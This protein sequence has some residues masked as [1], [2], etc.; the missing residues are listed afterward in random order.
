MKKWMY[1][2]LVVAL[3]VTPLSVCAQPLHENNLK[4]SISSALEKVQ[5]LQPQDSIDEIRPEGMTPE[6]CE[7]I[8]D[9]RFP[10]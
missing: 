8:Q 6:L 4:G 3:A 9:Y 1:A 7:L 5:K 10:R 2:V